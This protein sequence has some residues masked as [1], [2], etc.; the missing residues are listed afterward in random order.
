MQRV[1]AARQTLNQR[2]REA[3]VAEIRR[4][5]REQ[6]PDPSP[7]G[8][9][10]AWVSPLREHN[11]DRQRILEAHLRQLCGR[12]LDELQIAGR[13]GALEPTVG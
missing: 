4:R 6:P 13:Q 7:R 1:A 8:P 10:E 5:L 2:Q 11:E 12:G 3:R 9:L